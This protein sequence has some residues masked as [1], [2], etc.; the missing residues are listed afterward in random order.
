MWFFLIGAH[1]CRFRGNQASMCGWVCG[2]GGKVCGM[3]GWWVSKQVW[4][5][6][7]EGTRRGN[8]PAGRATLLCLLHK[9]PNL[10]IYRLFVA[11]QKMPSLIPSS[12]DIPLSV[13]RLRTG[14]TRSQ[15]KA[16]LHACFP[17]KKY[18]AF[19]SYV[20]GLSW[21]WG[22]SARISENV[23]FSECL[24]RDIFGFVVKSVCDWLEWGKT[25]APV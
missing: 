6:V 19:K 4:L 21:F 8:F 5:W 12:S 15:S 18:Q 7:G 2:Y 23:E 24:R 22:K 17:N 11:E 14:Q 16:E 1:Q 10:W 25:R 9:R 20:L 13:W 3:S